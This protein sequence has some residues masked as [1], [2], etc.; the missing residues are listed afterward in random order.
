MRLRIVKA[1]EP[2]WRYKPKAKPL[3]DL[4][5]RKEN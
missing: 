4:G 3:N 2:V 5:R 1:D